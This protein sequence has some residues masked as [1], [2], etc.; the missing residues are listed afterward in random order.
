M[1]I[2]PKPFLSDKSGASGGK[3][4]HNLGRDERDAL[5]SLSPTCPGTPASVLE[6][7]QCP[8]CRTKGIFLTH[9]WI[10]KY[11]VCSNSSDFYGTH[12]LE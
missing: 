5:V 6:E 2:K 1:T 11:H 4:R 10:L 3:P 9:S 8:Q 12:L 7:E